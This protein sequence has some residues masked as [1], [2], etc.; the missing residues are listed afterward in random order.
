[1]A[2]FGVAQPV[3]RV[4]DPR[5]LLGGGRY[6]DDIALAERGASASCCAARTPRP[7]SL[8][9]DTAAAK[10][11]PG[12]LARLHRAPTSRRTAS[13][14]CPAPS[15][16]KNRDGTDRADAAASRCW[17]RRAS[18]T[19]ATRWPSSS[20]RPRRPARDA[21]ELIKVEYDILPSSTDLAAAHGAG[22]AAGLA[23]RAEQHRASTGRPATR[24]KTEALFA[25]AAPRDPA[26]RGQQPR[27]SSNSM[28]ARAAL[29]EYDG[30]RWTLH[31]NTQGGWGI[32]DLLGRGRVQGRRRQVPRHHARRRRRL[33]HEAVPL[34]RARADLLRRPQARPPG[35]V[36]QRAQPRRSCPTRMAATTS[37]RAR[38]RSTRTASSSRMRTRNVANMGAYLSHLRAVHPDR[39]RHQ[40]AGQ[41]LRVP[42]DLRQRHRRV[43][44]HRAGRRLSR[45]RAAGEQL[46][47]RAADRHR[48]A[49]DRHRP[50]RAAPAQHGAAVRDAVPHARWTR[51]TTAATSSACWTRRCEKM[52]WAGF[53]AR[54]AAERAAAASSAASAWPTTSRRPA[55]PTASAPRSASPMTGSS[56]SMSAPKAPARATRPPMCSSPP[57]GSASTAT[58]SAIKQGDTDTIPTGGGTGGARSLYSEGPGHPGH[59]GERDRE[60]QAGGV[61][62]AGGGGRR[63]RVRGRPV[64]HRR[65]RPRH[66]HP[67]ARRA[68]SAA[69]ARARP[70]S[71]RPRSRR[72]ASTPSRT[73]ATWP[74]SRS[75]PTPA[76][77][78]V[79]RYIVC[80]DVG[81]AV[82][83]MIVRG[84]V[85]GG[86]AQGFGQAVHGA[87]RPTTRRPASCCPAA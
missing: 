33:R 85:H 59:R 18:A 69:A 77:S 17:P 32:K 39:R 40:G 53:E 81:K 70:S 75:T 66:G 37:P 44:Q 41:R 4:E 24:R 63:H 51:S 13:A 11:V 29:A 80:D 62:G 56:T 2:K 58:R 65:H 1:M 3:R 83:P 68:R 5:L 78:T 73:A 25:Q 42:G 57:T 60:G 84:Q 87:H 9:I 61:R 38:S 15:R 71:T 12:V 49:R 74:R 19:S 14:T 79:L 27:S 7:A 46:P 50:H 76:R 34:R 45:R 48:G 16:C 82:N 8:S 36:D 43:H 26:D 67:R 54:R 6:T 20:P 28:E 35:E 52:D 72:S 30:D 22:A 23:G 64:Q 47:G 86:V 21:A 55:A 31:T 10:A